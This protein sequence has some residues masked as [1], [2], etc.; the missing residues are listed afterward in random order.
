MKSLCCFTAQLGDFSALCVFVHSDSACWPP[1]PP[2]WKLNQPLGHQYIWE[3]TVTN[4]FCL[5]FAGTLLPRRA[6]S[7]G[8]NDSSRT[9]GNHRQCLWAKSARSEVCVGVC[10]CISVSVCVLIGNRVIWLITTLHSIIHV[11][12]EQATSFIGI[13]L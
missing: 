2:K 3:A 7:P 1:R 8:D 6:A 9:A 11:L 13:F 12:L 5:R 10:V 4:S